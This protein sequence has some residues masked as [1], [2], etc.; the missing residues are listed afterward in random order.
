MG[1]SG[2]GEV[3]LVEKEGEALNH[4]KFWPKEEGSSATDGGADRT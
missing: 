1:L 2:R 4:E 3:A